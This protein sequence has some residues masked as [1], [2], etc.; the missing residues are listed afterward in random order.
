M[1]A[2]SAE[3]FLSSD[4]V[5]PTTS[6]YSSPSLSTTP[7]SHRVCTA[8]PLLTCVVCLP[9]CH[10]C[11]WLHVTAPCSIMCL[12]H[13]PAPSLLLPV[14]AHCPSQSLL[15]PVTAPPHHCSS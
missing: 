1:T 6:S 5:H 7:G 3:N 9:P 4:P 13:C 14:P 12:H 2:N 8:E 15:L 11:L 10:R